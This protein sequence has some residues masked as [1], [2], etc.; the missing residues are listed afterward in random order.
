MPYE[1]FDIDTSHVKRVG[2]YI[3]IDVRQD[4]L[5]IFLKDDY[6]DGFFWFSD[7]VEPK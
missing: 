3:E 2:D 7:M 4:V 1:K 5:L 6:Y